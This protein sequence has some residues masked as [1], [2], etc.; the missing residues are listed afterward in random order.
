MAACFPLLLAPLASFTYSS[1]LS[2]LPGAW[3]LAAG[4]PMLPQLVIFAAAGVIEARY[5]A[6]GDKQ[7]D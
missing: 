4:L 6:G 2:S 3:S 5:P 1:T 7:A